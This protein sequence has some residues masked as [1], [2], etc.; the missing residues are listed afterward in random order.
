MIDALRKSFLQSS[1]HRSALDGVSHIFCS[2][3]FS[4][5]GNLP[6]SKDT[7]FFFSLAHFG[8]ASLG[9]PTVRLIG[10]A[11]NKNIFLRI[12]VSLFFF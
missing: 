5:E 8:G 9:M 7:D 2:I 3:F 4:C 10:T 11:T 1:H 12:T 6:L